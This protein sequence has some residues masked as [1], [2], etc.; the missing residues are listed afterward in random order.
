MKQL[1]N[2]FIRILFNSVDKFALIFMNHSIDTHT[3]IRT[4][5]SKKEE[6]F[7]LPTRIISFVFIRSFTSSCRS[8]SRREFVEKIFLNIENG[9][10][11]KMKKIDLSVSF[12]VRNQY[13]HDVSTWSPQV[14]TSNLFQRS[15]FQF[16]LVSSREDSIKLNM[17]WKL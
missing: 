15:F 13:D 16:R 8:F 12:L 4:N 9:E 5:I 1:K 11:N 3:H 6:S 17:P 2:V 10:K 7:S 14:K